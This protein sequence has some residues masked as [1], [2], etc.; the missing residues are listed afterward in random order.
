MAQTGQESAAHRNL[1]ERID[2]PAD[3]R[4][5]ASAAGGCARYPQG[6]GRSRRRNAELLA[7]VMIDDGRGWR[8]RR[9][10]NPRYSF[11]TV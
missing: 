10:S 1:A 5:G 11:S 3:W 9:D 4:A 6:Q 7:V 8:R 2:R